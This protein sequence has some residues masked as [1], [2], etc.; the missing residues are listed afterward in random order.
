MSAFKKIF[1]RSLWAMAS[2]RGQGNNWQQNLEYNAPRVL[3]SVI[4]D[5][6][7]T[8]LAVA[9]AV[10]FVVAGAYEFI[11]TSPLSAAFGNAANSAA[12]ATPNQV[13]DSIMNLPQT[14]LGNRPVGDMLGSAASGINPLLGALAGLLDE[15]FG[16][17]VVL[18][19]VVIRFGHRLL[20]LLIGDR[21]ASKNGA[22]LSW[23]ALGAAVLIFI[24]AVLA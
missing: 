2:R 12:L 22:M 17:L 3:R 5:I 20:S 11:F 9:L 24:T 6:I 7:F 8:V 1:R 21:P 18:V 19:A 14:D 16:V 23:F 13:R 4:G 10:M 15:I